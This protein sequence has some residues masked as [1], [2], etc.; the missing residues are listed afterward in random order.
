M[1]FIVQEPQK[2]QNFFLVY[3]PEDYSFDTEPHDGNGFTSIMI[4][5]LQLE[6]DDEGRI[7]YVWGLCPLIKYKDT[8]EIPKNYKSSSLVA[9]LDKPPIP[10]ISYR[11]NE[12]RRWP[13]YINK[14]KGWVCIGNPKSNGKEMIEFVPNCIATLE[15]QE[16]IAIW[17]KPRDLLS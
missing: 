11:L 1:K 3:R 15:D 4:N 8:N 9:L 5:D 17:L 16:I 6:I 7:I 14:K 13:I 12:D 10:G 2:D